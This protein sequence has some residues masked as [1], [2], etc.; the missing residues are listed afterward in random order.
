MGMAH[1]PG[2]GVGGECIPVDTLYLIKQAEKIGFDTKL[3]RQAREVNDYMPH[4]MIDLLVEELNNQNISI[5]TSKITILGVAYKKNIHDYRLSATFPIVEE[6]NKKGASFV[7]CDPLIGTIRDKQF[8]L[9]SLSD[10]F[11]DSDA[12][13]LVTDHDI[14]SNL[15]LAKIKNEMKHAIIIDGRNFFNEEKVTS[16]GFTYRAIGKP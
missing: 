14:F 11:V 10:V 1:Y 13:L 6:L 15:E 9:T 8:Q 3:L 2:A 5:N 12:I 16:L 4:Y 7:V